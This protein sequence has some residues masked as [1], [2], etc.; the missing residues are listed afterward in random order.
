MLAR[1]PPISAARSAPKAATCEATVPGPSVGRGWAVP[2]LDLKLAYVAPGSFQM[3]SDVGEADERPVH[4][5]RLSHGFWMGTLQV[6]QAQY[7]AVMLGPPHPALAREPDPSTFKDA[8]N[9]VETVS[10][11]DAMAF[12]AKL[13]ACERVAG[14]LPAALEYRLPTE[15]EWEYAARG[16]K[17][18]HGFAYSGSDTAA[19]VA[20]YDDNSAKHPHPVGQKQPN[21]LGLYDMSGNV[22]E[23]C[24]GWYDASYY[25]RSPDADPENAQTTSYRVRRGGSWIDDAGGVRSAYRFGY[26]PDHANG[27]VGFR[28]CLAPL[29]VGRWAPDSS[30]PAILSNR[31]PVGRTR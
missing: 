17:Q 3:G 20:W 24:L 23:W 9:P 31:R 8:R 15:A 16:G 11:H 5:V 21:E 4:E 19:E 14:R 1:T 27:T 6:T 7:K 13:T 26:G 22:W 28:V 12:C 25:D 30:G 10:W 18:S 29:P 2:D